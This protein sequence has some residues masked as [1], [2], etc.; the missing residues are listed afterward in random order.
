M[1][2]SRA[3]CVVIPPKERGEKHPGIGDARRASAVAEELSYTLRQ[4]MQRN[5]SDDTSQK[6]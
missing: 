3:R 6:R 1:N 2:I 4:W 5:A